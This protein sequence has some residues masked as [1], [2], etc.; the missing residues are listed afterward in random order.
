[1]PCPD[2]DIY[3]RDNILDTGEVVPSPSGPWDPT[4]PNERVRHWQ[5]ADIKIDAPPFQ[6]VDALVDG[7]EFDNPTHRMLPFGYRIETVLGL[8]HENPIRATSN[9]VYVQAHN[10]GPQP[11][12]SVDVRL[13]WADAGAGLPLLPADFWAAFATDTYTQSVW[14]LIGK[15]TIPTLQ[16]G[17]PHVVRFDWTPPAATSDHVCLLAML[18]SVDDPLLPQVERN[19]D[20]LTRSNKRVSHKNVHPVNAVALPSGRA[21]WGLLRFNNTFATSRPF[22]LRVEGASKANWTVALV[23]P[24]VRLQRP[25][26]ESLEGLRAR[27]TDPAQRATWVAEAEASGAVSPALLGLRPQFDDPLILEIE[28]LRA[29]ADVRGVVI[30]PERP[31][32]ALVVATHPREA[33]MAPLRLDVIQLV[34]DKPIGG[35]TFLIA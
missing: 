5:S 18:D 8:A 17:R 3:L 30:E 26:S 28:T 34:D 23:L 11:A 19:V 9:R 15:Q 10:R 1:M 6:T 33:V 24:P 32:P 7:V 4:R 35:S 25:L 20:A 21:G 27:V 12:A 31:L 14:R 2:V 13:L 29:G 22:T 16:P